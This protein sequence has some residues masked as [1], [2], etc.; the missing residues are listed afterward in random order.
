MAK[1]CYWCGDLFGKI[2]SDGLCSRCREKR[3]QEEED[4]ERSRRA[5]DKKMRDAM[6][7]DCPPGKP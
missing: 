6:G 4:D 3:R 7:D 5:A 2:G 1:R